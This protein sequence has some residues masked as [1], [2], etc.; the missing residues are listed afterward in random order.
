MLIF[1]LDAIQEK[2]V[3][4]RHFSLRFDEFLLEG[5][6]A[7]FAVD[8]LANRAD[9][10]LPGF[11]CFETGRIWRGRRVKSPEQDIVHPEG[12][13][14]GQPAFEDDLE[15]LSAREIVLRRLGEAWFFPRSPS[16][17]L[18]AQ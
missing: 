4:N 17:D 3:G 18:L 14:R 1:V 16:D 5:P 11:A 7:R 9:M 15:E 10:F 2:P 6:E 8:G 12:H 13:A